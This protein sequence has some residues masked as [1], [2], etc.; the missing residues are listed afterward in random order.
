MGND[1]GRKSGGDRPS[2]GRKS[3]DQGRDGHSYT[4]ERAPRTEVFDTLPPPK[5]KPPKEKDE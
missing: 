2:R 5:P 4:E 1:K 3:E